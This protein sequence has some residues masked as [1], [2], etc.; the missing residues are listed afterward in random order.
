[1]IGVEYT[2]AL[3]RRQILS[4]N[5]NEILSGVYDTATFGLSILES[6]FYVSEKGHRSEASPID[7]AF[8]R[9]IYMG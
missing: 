3:Y 9:G 2:Y 8:V 6:I 4:Q 5:I 7:P 1:M